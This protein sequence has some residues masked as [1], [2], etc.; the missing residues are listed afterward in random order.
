[1]KANEDA[2]PPHCCL[3]LSLIYTVAGLILYPMSTGH[4]SCAWLCV[5][6][7]GEAREHARQRT[8]SL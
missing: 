1:M 2:V 6:S 8:L 4:L 7:W 5:G 3:S